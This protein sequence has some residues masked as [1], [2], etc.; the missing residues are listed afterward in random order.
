LGYLNFA[1]SSADEAFACGPLDLACLAY[2]VLYE[3]QSRFVI[4]FECV[5][6]FLHF[7]C[8]LAGVRFKVF[9]K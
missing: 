8:G 2:P 4:G 6:A 1:K 7:A 5:N 3:L 9:E